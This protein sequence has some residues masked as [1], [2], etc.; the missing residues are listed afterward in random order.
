MFT[1]NKTQA[2]PV[3]VSRANLERS[4]G[5]A[6]VIVCNSGCANACTGDAGLRVSQSTVEFVAARFGCRP[7]EVL[8]GSTGVIGVDLDL[9]KVTSGVTKASN[10]LSREGQHDAAFAIM[11]TDSLPK[12]AAVRVET[13]AGPFLSAA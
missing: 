2:A 7:E 3:L 4:G 9:A 11:T 5:K 6:R 1:T 12:E 13:P 8:V 10:V